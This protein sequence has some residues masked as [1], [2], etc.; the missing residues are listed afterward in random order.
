MDCLTC[1][2]AKEVV[3]VPQGPAI[4]GAKD[5]SGGVVRQRGGKGGPALPLTGCPK[6]QRGQMG[7]Q[8]AAAQ[9][10]QVRGGKAGQRKP[11]LGHAPWPDLS[12]T[13]N[14]RQ[15]MSGTELGKGQ[16]SATMCQASQPTFLLPHPTD[17][18]N[19]NGNLSPGGWL[20]SASGR[21]LAPKDNEIYPLDLTA[22]VRG[23]HPCQAHLM[24]PTVP[25]T[26]ST[27]HSMAFSSLRCG[28]RGGM[29]LSLNGGRRR[30][31]GQCHPQARPVTSE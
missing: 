3:A 19:G 29:H 20:C 24:H 1:H 8:W 10:R 4:S 26:M 14:K 7:V 2:P 6:S 22:C 15:S 27:K 25:S 12:P 28:R 31:K 23:R 5:C 13:G 18:P 11:S 9:Q 30:G 17:S 16:S 21:A